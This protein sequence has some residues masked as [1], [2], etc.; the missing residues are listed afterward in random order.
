MEQQVA[1]T[2]HYVPKFILR[3][4]LANGRDP[5]KDQV[6]VF[7]KKDGRGF[8]TSIDNIMAERR[9]H[10]FMSADE[11]MA[12]F[13]GVACRLEDEVLPTYRRIIET[14]SL[15]RTPEERES[16]GLLV[17]FQ[18]L[19][20]RSGRDWFADL[21]QL[22]DKKLKK[23]G[24]SIEQLEGYEPLTEDRLKRNHVEFIRHSLGKFTAIIAAKDM[25]LMQAPVRRSFYLSDNPVSLNNSFPKTPFHGNLGIGVVGIE[26]YLPL[27]ADLMLAAWCP[28]II[29]GLREVH[30]E[31]MRNISSMVLS[32][33]LMGNPHAE[34]IDVLL[35]KMRGY[36]DHLSTFFQAIG[37]GQ[38]ILLTSDNMDYNNSMQV[39]DAR[40]H[41]VC[42]QDDF[43]LAREFMEQHPR[44]SGRRLEMGP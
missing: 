43:A 18:M 38:P 27:S 33:T 1:Q 5:K 17:A 13:E 32:P 23:L 22:L 41:I 11:I 30:A 34:E 4:F 39:S 40:R 19:R 9:F 35:E 36:R 37:M 8:L 44:S 6:H 7:S 24:T 21:D 31:Q 26:I 42:P 28:S 16:L 2:Q 29:R 10:D 15:Q 25:V 3:N 12:S 14:R 20:T